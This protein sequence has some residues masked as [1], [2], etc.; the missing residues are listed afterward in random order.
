[1][2]LATSHGPRSM[3][4]RT[5]E[6]GAGTRQAPCRQASHISSQDASKA[7]D[8]PGHHPVAGPERLR[9][10]GTAAPR[11]RRTRRPSG[12]VT[13]TPFGVPVEPEVKMIQASSVGS[14]PCVPAGSVR[15]CRGVHA[16]GVRV[17]E[18]AVRR[19]V[20]EDRLLLWA[21]HRQLELVAD[22]SRDGSFTEHQLGAFFRVVGVHRHVRRAGL[23]RAEN[24]D[25]QVVVPGRDPDADPVARPDSRG[26][27][28]VG[29]L[30]RLLQQ[31]AVAEADAAVIERRLVG[32]P[33]GRLLKHIHK[34]P[35]GRRQL[36]ASQRHG[37]II[38][39]VVISWITPSEHI[40]CLLYPDRVRTL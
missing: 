40:N 31:F 11:R 4:L 19:I 7:T 35:R 37:R 10:A 9:P 26:G 5:S 2:P 38:R 20:V 3:P 16:G 24:R 23:E 8:R 25:V 15:R 33:V 27:Q 36:P 39:R 13:A 14:G 22:G 17:V 21:G 12:G 34:R 28:T 29:E 18:G 32:V 6:R 1:M 30:G